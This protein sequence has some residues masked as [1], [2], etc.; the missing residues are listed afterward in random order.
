MIKVTQNFVILAS[1][2]FQAKENCS[3]MFHK[4]RITRHCLKEIPSHKRALSKPFSEHWSI[5]LLNSSNK[6][7]SMKYQTGGLLGACSMRWPLEIYLFSIERKR[8]SF[9][10]SY[11]C[12]IQI[13]NTFIDSDPDLQ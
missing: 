4:I 11:V 9:L 2:T 5:C 8:S 7:C 10:K 12:L 13:L 1:H 3:N 6:E